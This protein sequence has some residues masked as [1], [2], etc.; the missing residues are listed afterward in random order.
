[1]VQS[2]NHATQALSKKAQEKKEKK[3]IYSKTCSV[4]DEVGTVASLAGKC[5]FCG[6]IYKD[7]SDEILYQDDHLIIIRDKREKADAH[8]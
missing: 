6:I 8:Y 3:E 7:K 2:T 5:T 1:M 4:Y